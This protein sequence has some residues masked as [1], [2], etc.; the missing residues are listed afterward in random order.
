MEIQL[1]GEG[2][3]HVGG[4]EGV[5]GHFVR[6]AASG[7]N[8]LSQQAA[9]KRFGLEAQQTRRERNRWRACHP[10]LVIGRV[11]KSHVTD[12]EDRT[13]QLGDLRRLEIAYPE[14][15]EQPLRV[16]PPSRVLITDSQEVGGGRLGTSGRVRVVRDGRT[17]A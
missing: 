3:A 9:L 13:Q 12:C 11:L 6:G 14:G 16:T 15:R 1:L 2:V 7:D 10:G 4:A 5:V 17:S 8:E